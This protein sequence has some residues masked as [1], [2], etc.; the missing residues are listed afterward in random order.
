MSA[1]NPNDQYEFF[2][3]IR[4]TEDGRLIVSAEGVVNDT[5]VTAGF[6][7]VPNS[8]L[9]LNRSDGNE[10]RIDAAEFL[11]DAFVT[12]GTYDPNTQT[13]TFTNNLGGTFV[14]D[15]FELS[16]TASNGLTEVGNDVQLGGTLTKDTIIEG[17]GTQE[18]LLGNV[19]SINNCVTR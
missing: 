19:N 17:D 1:T 7:D 4:L 12:E 9:V 3:Y 2:K 18:F 8:E 5:F 14:V 13:I 11:S 15:G 10:V 6:I 16:T